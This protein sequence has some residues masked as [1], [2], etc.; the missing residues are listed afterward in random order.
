MHCKIS[1]PEIHAKFAA[2]R[3]RSG[4]GIAKVFARSCFTAVWG[5][6]N[7]FSKTAGSILKVSTRGKSFPLP[8]LSTSAKTLA[9]A[10]VG[11]GILEDCTGMIS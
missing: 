3:T 6:R 5:F 1:A 8:F 11:F 2:R 9:R 4:V 7:N 10:V